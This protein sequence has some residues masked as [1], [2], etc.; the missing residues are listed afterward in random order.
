MPGIARP[1]VEIWNSTMTYRYPNMDAEIEGLKFSSIIYGGFATCSFTLYRKPWKYFPELALGNIVQVRS[2]HKI[3]WSGRLAAPQADTTDLRISIEADGP[4]ERLKSRLSL[5][6]LAA[7]AKG[8]AWITTN[9]IGDTDLAYSAGNIYTSDYAFPAGMDFLPDVYYAEAV[10]KINSANGYRYGF[11]PPAQTHLLQAKYFDFYPVSSTPD[12]YLEMADCET[13]IQYTLEGIENLLRVTY[14]PDGNIYKYF[15]Y[16]N[17]DMTN[18]TG[19]PVPDAT[20]LALYGRRDGRLVVPGSAT[21]AQAAQLASIA[22]AWRKRLRPAA[23]IVATRITDTTG[24]VVPLPEVE[25]GKVLHIRGL[26]PGEFTLLTAQ[27][28]N[29]LCTWPIVLAEPDIDAG[30][31]TLSPGGLSNA[32]ER[33]LARMELAVKR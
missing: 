5:V 8:S 7:G 23:D 28:V 6:S 32:L 33:V 11:F 1:T 31:V 3:V 16:P 24:A 20:S 25:A 9:L 26:N 18:F 27:S 13:R 4:I 22:L 30:T 10:E 21:L 2:R 12:Y 14:S 19:T 17:T 15:W 29:E